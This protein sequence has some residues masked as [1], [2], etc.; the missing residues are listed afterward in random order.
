[1]PRGT[2]AIGLW[3]KHV[4]TGRYGYFS[5]VPKTPIVIERMELVEE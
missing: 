1:M 4:H 2:T 3:I 5:N